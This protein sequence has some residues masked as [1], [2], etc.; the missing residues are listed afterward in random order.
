MATLTLNTVAITGTDETLVAAAVGGDAIP[1]DAGKSYLIVNNGSGSSITV[2]IDA[3]NTNAPTGLTF[4]D[5]T[6][7]VAAG[8]R[9]IIGPFS[10][11][12]FN[13]TN[14]RVN[15][16]YSAVTTVTVGAFKFT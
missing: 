5:P 12:Y 4:T 15:V 6:V 10:P 11:S 2:T 1:N 8:V 16:T 14:N 3:V 7:T 13:D 9:K